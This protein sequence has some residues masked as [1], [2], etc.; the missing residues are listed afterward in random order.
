M[1]APSLRIQFPEKL[2]CLFKPKRYKILYG[3]RGGAKSWG[4]TRALLIKG[5][6]RKM[7]I[8]CCREI[9]DSIEE[10]VH[11]LLVNQIEAMGLQAVYTVQKNKIFSVTNGT[12]FVFEGLKH[13]VDSIK[14]LEGA[15]IVWVEEAYNV[16][17][18]T[19]M[20]LIPTVRKPDSEIWISF[21]PEL[22]TDNTYIRFVVDPPPNATVCEMNWRDNPWF[23]DVLRDEMLSLKSKNYDEYLH[24]WE[25]KT[26]QMLEGAVYKVELRKLTEE[27]RI[28]RVPPDDYRPVDV[29][30]D[31]GWSDY[32]SLWFIQKCAMDF[33]VLK[34]YQSQFQ[35]WDHY[36]KYIQDT[37]YR[38]GRVFIPHDGK[39]KNIQTGKSIEDITKATYKTV[40]VPITGLKE[41]IN[42]V[43]TVLPQCYFDEAG[44]QD[45]LQALRHYKYEKKTDVSFTQEPKHDNASHFADAF[46][47]FAVGF[48]EAAGEVDERTERVKKKLSAPTIVVQIPGGP[49]SGWMG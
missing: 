30:C 45:G 5:M 38:I 32:T 18:E 37:G 29:F 48:R 42:M 47:T 43:R 8:V 33:R 19:W 10:S 22:D 49:S 16:S 39:S 28:C 36:L 2:Q 20:K 34:S 14:S 44:T 6:Q 1:K 35:K 4:I 31:L 27:K 21:N 3:G 11:R 46:R 26:V 40:V 7:L 17:H 41:G 25:G 12:E 24:V 15:D 23:P 13:R 9:Q